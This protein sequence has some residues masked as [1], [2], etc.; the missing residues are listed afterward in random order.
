M[1]GDEL[2]EAIADLRADQRATQVQYQDGDGYVWSVKAVGFDEPNIVLR[3]D[4]PKIRGLEPVLAPLQLS[5]KGTPYS[6]LCGCTT[7]N[8]MG[9][10]ESL[11]FTCT[12]CGRE[13]EGVR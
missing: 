12:S 6:C 5:I 8:Q 4:R 1:T 2:I 7:F 10:P 3:Y 9:G 13:H 11:L